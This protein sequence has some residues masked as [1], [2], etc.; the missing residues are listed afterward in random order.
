M[1]YFNEIKEDVLNNKNTAQTSLESI[2]ENTNKNITELSLRE[3]LDGDIDFS[4][5]K[6]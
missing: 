6:V 4:I 2:L 5:L 1:N 3:S